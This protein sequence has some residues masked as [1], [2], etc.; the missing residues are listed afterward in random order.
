MAFLQ[1]IRFPNLVIVALTQYL[2]YLQLL[3][4]ALEAAGISPVFDPLH[5][6]IFA[7][8]TLAITAAG[9]ILNDLIDY[10]VDLIN[11]PD[12][13]VLHRRILFQTAYWLVACLLLPAFFA[14]FYLAAYVGKL[15]LLFLYP[16]ALAGLLWY[17]AFLKRKA[18]AGNIVIA[19]YCAGAGAVLWLAEKTAL[20]ELA[21]Q[22]PVA[23]AKTRSIFIWFL[24]F[25]FLATLFRELIKDIEDMKGDRSAHFRTAPLL[26]GEQK[27]RTIALLLGLLLLLF[28]IGYGY[29][30]RQQ[31]GLPALLYLAC[32]VGLPLLGALGVLQRAHT[33]AAYH[34]VST[35]IKVVM[36]MGILL[37][38]FV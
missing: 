24:T 7:G 1:L 34:R 33:K 6:A 4:P 3:R 26:W 8:V 22:A 23:Y 19:L 29:Q 21:L 32:A 13:V 27:A 5:F 10:E 30:Y 35:L 14:A 16:A 2:L 18:L 28:I 20:G 17:N 31:F 9:N 11:R 37:L 25:A 12:K 15:Y 36:L 38:L